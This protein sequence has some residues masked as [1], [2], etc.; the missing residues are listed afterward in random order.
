M[1]NPPE[2]IENQ[3]L[4]PN[5]RF[6][7]S[8]TATSVVATSKVA[9]QPPVKRQS[10]KKNTR[11]SKTLCLRPSLVQFEM[12]WCRIRGFPLWPGNYLLLGIIEDLLLLIYY[13]I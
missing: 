1:K 9:K 12:I 4:E 7:H 8:S 13:I 5:K 10:K 6:K 11:L 3:D 2:A